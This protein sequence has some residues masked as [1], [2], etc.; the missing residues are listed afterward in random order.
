M[1]RQQ[2]GGVAEQPQP[3][4]AGDDQLQPGRGRLHDD[5]GPA[6]QRDRAGQAEIDQGVVS[7]RLRLAGQ[8]FLGPLGQGVDQ[9]RPP[10]RPGRRTGRPRVGLG[11]RPQQPQHLEPAV[12]RL[13]QGIHRRR[14]GMITAGGQL[15]QGQVLPD[16]QF[17]QRRVGLGEPHRGHGLP[18]DRRA[19]RRMIMVG[20]GQLA[21]V[22]EQTAEQQQVRP[23][24]RGQVPRAPRPPPGPS[25]GRPCAGA[26]DC[27][28]AGPGSLPSWGSSVGCSR[29]GRA[30]PRPGPGSRRWPAGRAAPPAASAGHGVGSGGACAPRF[31]A[32][33]G[34]SIRP[35]LAARAPARSPSSGSAGEVD[36]PSPTSSRWMIKPCGAV[37]YCGRRSRRPNGNRR[38]AGSTPRAARTVRSTA[39]P[40]FRAAR[41]TSRRNSSSSSY[42]SSLATSGTSTGDQPVQGPA[43]GHL[44][45]VADIQQPLV[46]LAHPGMRLVGQPGRRQR[47]QHDHVPQA[48]AAL[49]EIGLQ[50]RG[51]VADCAGAA[52]PATPAPRAAAAGHWPASRPTAR[53]APAQPGQGLRRP[54]AGRA[55]RPRR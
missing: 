33:I 11:Q 49:L 23:L 19:D 22:V 53:T 45:R 18:G 44:E 20:A 37:S 50:Q 27:A 54:A 38:R 21:D 26:P 35:R 42:R 12:D 30:S 28:A 5:P 36:R 1:R 52:R 16:Q 31:S 4:P 29:P 13:D 10:R 51:R 43:G 15:G 24:H 46:R 34:D 47:P 14:V 8:Q 3:V 2:P 41:L 7:A 17:H 40:I 32:V 6:V 55:A 25:A 39:C 9:L 48:A